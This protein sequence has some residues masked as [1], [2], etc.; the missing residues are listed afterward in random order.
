MLHVRNV[1]KV[2]LK[3][4]LIREFIKTGDIQMQN[5][6]PQELPRRLHEPH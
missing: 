2:M 4:T 1:F 5:I 3:N 6:T